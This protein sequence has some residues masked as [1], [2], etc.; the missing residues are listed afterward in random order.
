MRSCRARSR[1]VSASPVAF[2]TDTFGSAFLITI[3]M[4]VKLVRS[5]DASVIWEEPNYLFREDMS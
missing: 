2:P 3:Q 4:S 5:K 1:S